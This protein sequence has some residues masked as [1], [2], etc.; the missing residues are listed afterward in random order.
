MARILNKTCREVLNELHYLVGYVTLSH[1]S[2]VTCQML[3]VICHM[4]AVIQQLIICEIVK[5]LKIE[6]KEG[7]EEIHTHRQ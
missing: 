6:P 2:A 5:I 1:I 4:T 7:E 3:F